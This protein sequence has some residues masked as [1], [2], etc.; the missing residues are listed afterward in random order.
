MIKI[1]SILAALFAMT[2]AGPCAAASSVDGR[3]FHY[4]DVALIP[5]TVVNGGGGAWIFTDSFDYLPGTIMGYN[6]DP[7]IALWDPAGRLVAFNDNVM[8]GFRGQRPSTSIS[9]HD[10]VLHVDLA[11]G[12][13]TVSLGSGINLPRTDLL[14]DGFRLDHS[15]GRLASCATCDNNQYWNLQTTAGTFGGPVLVSA[16][17]EPSSVLMLA[18]GLALTGLAGRRRRGGAA[19][20]QPRLKR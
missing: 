10:A 5:L 6:F 18:F 20:D 16:V 17:P 9:F 19:F 12:V 3:L 15:T 2:A 8:T 7:A 1:A 14:S 4:G 11:P 13:Y